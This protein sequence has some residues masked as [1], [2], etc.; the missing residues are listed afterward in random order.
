MPNSVTTMNLITAPANAAV[1]GELPAVQPFDLRI[2][3]QFLKGFGACKGDQLLTDDSITKAI[4]VEGQ[5]IVFRVSPCQ[6]GVRYELACDEAISPETEQRVRAAIDGYLSLSDDLTDF[7]ALADADEPAYAAM[8]RIMH[9]L[10]QVRFLTIAEIGVWALVSQR[11]PKAVA[12]AMK[13]RITALGPT[14]TFEG[15]RYQAFPDVEQLVALSPED[16]LAL[17]RNDRKAQYLANLMTGLHEIGEDYLRTAPYDAAYAALRQI[18]GVGDF[19]A[20]AILLRG[21]GRMNHVPLEMPAFS[22][23]AAKA[24]GHPVDNA[25]LRRHYGPHLGYWSYYLHTGLGALRAAE[26][27]S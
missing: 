25:K 23:A 3:I 11:A 1:T 10:H 16:W 5:A 4:A 12:L 2:S 9:G 24:Y 15:L 27:G 19:T 6:A 26:V 13:R 20:T 8:V 21:L 14:T 7:Y 18:K 17:V 22:D